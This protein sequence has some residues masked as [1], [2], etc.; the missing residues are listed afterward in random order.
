MDQ[1]ELFMLIARVYLKLD[2][3]RESRRYLQLGRD[4]AKKAID[5]IYSQLRKTDPDVP[6]MSTEERMQQTAM[7]RKLEAVIDHAQLVFENVRDDWEKKQYE[8]A[9]ASSQ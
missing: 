3:M 2:Q 1:V 8:K 6:P 5:S 4:G 7:A 9:E